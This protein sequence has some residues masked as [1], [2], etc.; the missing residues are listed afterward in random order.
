M[1]LKKIIRYPFF[2]NP[3]LLAALWFG[4]FLVWYLSK[5]IPGGINNNYFIFAHSFKHALEQLPLYI[6]YPGEY[7]DLFLY[8][9]PFT[10]L[11]APFAIMP[12]LA[13][14]F[15]WCLANTALL[16]F[17]IKRLGLEKWQLAVV[18]WFSLNELF[19]ALLQLQYNIGIAGMI[20]L[21]FAFIERKKEFWAAL[22]IMLGAMTKVYGIVGL[23]FILFS[24]RKLHLL[25]GLLVWGIIIFI[26]PMLYSS[27]QYVMGEY[28]DWF[29]A[30]ADKNDCNAF[31]SYTNISLLGMVRKISH[32]AS[33]SDLW[34]IIPGLFL[35]I[36]PYF[37]ISQYD[38]KSFRL[39]YLAS[40]LLF[41]VLFS[42]GTES[43]GYITAIV[44][45]AIWYV[46]TPT[47]KTTPVLNTSLLIF[48]FILTSLSTTDVFPKF[49]RAGYII[50]YALKALPCA[51]I[52]FKIIWEQLTQDFSNRSAS[53]ALRKV[54]VIDIILP[55]YNPRPD[56]EQ[57]MITK[58]HELRSVLGRNIRFIVVNDGSVRGFT[59]EAV[60]TLLA[61][62]PGTIIVDNKQ[63][64]G[65]GAA[66]RDGLAHSDSEVA[67]YT[68]YDFPYEVHSM[69][70]VVDLLEQGYDI[71][72]AKRD[73][74]YYNQ[75]TFKRKV[76]SY[77]SK[78]LNF[79]LLGLTHVDTQGGLKGF[80]R[81]GKEYLAST[82][83]NRFL[84]DTEFIY[85]A[86]KNDDVLIAETTVT[87]RDEV[88]LLDMKKS[89]LKEELKNLFS[90][91]WRG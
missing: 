49:I 14:A 54:E 63:N 47:R 76:M 55:C 50:P 72:I 23:A 65:K 7:Q 91:A 90:I 83:T 77:A 62:V 57:V 19:T 43:W 8:G 68:D 10:A 29:L 24:K 34:L 51:V 75:L 86:S 44:A 5:V 53:L 71:V 82:R 25:L 59:Q 56:W 67:I 18:V 37:R 70:D 52:W 39:S 4:T 60:D 79:I 78:C 15:G 38:N 20:I 6:E 1:N 64:Q 40:A 80:N 89:V 22:M 88:V 61:A 28:C 30:L 46:S 2:Q 66:V 31:C 21:S 36:A 42:T 73:H 45:V 81:K 9:I 17:A 35:F 58:Y 41:M 16:Y 11:I 32:V 74:S 87:L 13:G 48:C 33:Y 3:F 27:P 84:F 26:V 85:H 12:P 69:F